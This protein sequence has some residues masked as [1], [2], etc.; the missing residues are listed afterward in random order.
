MK[1][2]V[3]EASSKKQIG[4]E[5]DR[6]IEELF[7]VESK[8]SKGGRRKRRVPTFPLCPKVQKMCSSED[9][10][11]DIKAVLGNDEVTSSV[12][13]D[14]EGAPPFHGFPA[15]DNARQTCLS[16][17]IKRIESE[18]ESIEVS[19]SVGLFKNENECTDGGSELFSASW[20]RTQHA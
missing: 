17:L 4:R 1:T 20:R 8:E 16:E 3:V 6:V 13:D 2:S 7:E 9:D 19:S 10:F 14:E 12:D 15:P 11:E 5:L 18:E